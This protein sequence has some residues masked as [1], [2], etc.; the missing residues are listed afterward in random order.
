MDQGGFVSFN[1]RVDA[2]K[3]RARS[4]SFADHF[5]HAKLFYNSQTSIEQDHIVSALS[6]EL[7]K[8][9]TVAIR[10]RMLGHLN[11]VDSS[12]AT[13]VGE[14]LGI[15]VPKDIEKPMNHGVGADDEGKQEP[16]KPNQNITP[17]DALSMLKN[18]TISNTIATRQIAFLCAEGVN[19]E[20]VKVMKTALQNAGAKA[21]V[22]APHLRTIISEEGTEIPVDQTYKIAAS[23]LFDGV[24]IPAGKGIAALSKIKE[25]KEFLNDSY[26]HCK[27]IA[28]EGEGIQIIKNNSDINN[29]PG[30]LMSENRSDKN[31]SVSFIKALGRHHFWEREKS[32]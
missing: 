6:F 18:P 20:S 23:V 29:D 16:T 15:Q 8:V 12:L 7:G 9:E 10:E 27:F 11:Q 2:H 3:V 28:A 31:L 5:S 1:E 13:K 30:V 26:H 24:F 17:S 22:I 19:A 25:V 14:K 4:K 21:V 32:L